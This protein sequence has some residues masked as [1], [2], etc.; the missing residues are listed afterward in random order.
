[1][2]KSEILQ[3]LSLKKKKRLE[4]H[5]LHGNYRSREHHRYVRKT[6]KKT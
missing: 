4:S 6:K 1:M 5:D 2:I 3:E